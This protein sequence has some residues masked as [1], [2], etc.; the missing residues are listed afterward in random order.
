MKIF[1]AGGTGVVGVPAVR[2]LVADG[3]TVSVVARSPEKAR[4]VDAAGATPVEADLFDPESVAAAVVGHEIVVNLATAIPPVN[5]AARASA[6]AHNDRLRLEASRHL[7]D[8]AVAAGAERFVQES[9]TFPY[10]D[11][12][13]RWLDEDEPRSDS[14][15]T[16]SV[17]VAEAN[18]DSVT[19]RG[20][21]GVVLRF[22]QFYGPTSGHTEFFV[23]TARRGF[24]PLLGDAD[25]YTSF[26]HADDAGAAVRAALTVPAGVYNV[27]E[28][29]PARRSM[30]DEVLAAAVGRRRLRRLPQTPVKVVNKGADILM[31]SHRISN[32]RFVD[33][34]GWRPAHPDPVV[35]W[36]EVAAEVRPS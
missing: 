8:A 9:I 23:R 15:F 6:W 20:G 19:E 11:G 17:G 27:S 33:V 18:A 12:G 25:G 16:A 5:K 4:V 35:G 13:D 21:V 32:R 36:A 26:V 30:L 22:A 1:V 29:E 2:A 3:H 31:R 10:D 34:S 7:A 14:P 28:D 24:S